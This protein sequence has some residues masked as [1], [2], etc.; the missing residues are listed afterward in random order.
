MSLQGKHI[1]LGVTGSIAAYK[2]AMLIRALVKEGAD[3]RVVMTRS[4]KDFITPL[5]LAT[6]CRHPILIDNFDPTD[7]AW[8][9]HISLGEWADHYL[10]APATA[11]TLAKMARGIADNL[12]LCTW[13]SA[14][15]PVSVAPAMD[16][17]MYRHPATQDNLRIL[18]DRYGAG[19]IEPE[20]GELAS[21]LVGKGR[22][23][24][25]E[26][27]V[28]CLRSR[29]EPHRDE[30][31]P[32]AGKKLIVTAGA[33]V[34]PI[35]PVRFVSN[36]STGKMGYAIAEALASRGAD[37]VL[38]SGMATAVL[39]RPRPNIMIEKALS[40]ADMYEACA[41]LFPAADGA[42]FCAAVAD[43]T[44]ARPLDEKYKHDPDTPFLLELKPTKDIA[45]EM[46]RIK[47]PGQI[48]VGFALETSPEAA[49]YARGKLEAKNL[50]LIVLNSLRDPGA[51]FGT[52]TNKVTLIDRDPDKPETPLPL[53]SK[54]AVAEDIAE[55]ICRKFGRKG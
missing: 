9:S 19:V 1:L 3:V 50:D 42:V 10:I 34:E 18:R 38:V 49:A 22:M 20:E 11:N 35:D 37:V 27:I 21:G 30:L 54:T 29:F 23:A 5:T 53:K 47:R 44:P 40:A 32:L 28:A 25:P 24:E 45:A 4:A 55:C 15:C 41:R 17:D 51:G 6:L 2:A 14:R 13:L 7:G 26:A 43:Y 12:L 48:T 52:D 46:G 33:T 8:N 16:L 31:P 39:S 36:Y